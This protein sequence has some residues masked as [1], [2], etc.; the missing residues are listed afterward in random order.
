M[1]IV[2]ATRRVERARRKI[3]SLVAK[4]RLRKGTGRKE[5][6]LPRLDLNIDGR[7]PKVTAPAS[8]GPEPA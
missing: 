7:A 4:A 3:A 6:I 2:V 5:V 8:G 1:P